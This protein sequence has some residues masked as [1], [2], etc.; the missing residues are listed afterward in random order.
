MGEP[1][2]LFVAIAT[3]DRRPDPEPLPKPSTITHA[4]ETSDHGSAFLLVG[5]C[6]QEG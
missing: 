2:S 6:Y 1:A 3:E 4:V 5:V